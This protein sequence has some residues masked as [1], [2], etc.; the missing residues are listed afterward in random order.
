MQVCMFTVCACISGYQS[1]SNSPHLSILYALI[2]EIV[3]LAA[4]THEALIVHKVG[5][6][7]AIPSATKGGREYI[8]TKVAFPTCSSLSKY[9]PCNVV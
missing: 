1:L 8:Y 6:V 9:F 3:G 4:E 7:V 5:A 2:A